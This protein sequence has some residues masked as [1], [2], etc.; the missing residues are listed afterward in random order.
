MARPSRPSVRFT[1]LDIAR[2]MNSAQI[3]K[4]TGPTCQP[5]S[6]V[7]DSR[8]DAGVCPRRSANCSDSTAKAIPTISWPAILALARRPS[9]RCLTILM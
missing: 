9:E 5:K 8:S 3:T 6:W 4:I 7:K 2:I 1:P